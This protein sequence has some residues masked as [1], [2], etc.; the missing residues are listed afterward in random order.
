MAD[1]TQEHCL[2][3]ALAEFDNEHIIFTVDGKT[4]E[5]AVEIL[6]VLW[7]IHHARDIGRW[8]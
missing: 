8:E 7:T 5:E 3:Y 4:D 2:D 6:R 1:P